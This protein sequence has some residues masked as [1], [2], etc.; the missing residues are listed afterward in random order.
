MS[1]L[2]PAALPAVLSRRE[3]EHE[4]GRA[5]PDVRRYLQTYID[6]VVY[7]AKDSTGY[8]TPRVWFKA[9]E[10]DA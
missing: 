9:A 5:I 10:V 6:I 3:G 7:C 2:R 1:G 8:H 4:A